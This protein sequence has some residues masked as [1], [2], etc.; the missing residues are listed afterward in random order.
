MTSV[1]VAAQ[2]RRINELALQDV[3]SLAE[4]QRQCAAELKALPDAIKEAAKAAEY[5]EAARLQERIDLLKTQAEELA[6]ARA[7]SVRAKRRRAPA[8]LLPADAVKSQAASVFG[9]RV[10][11][12]VEPLRPCVDAT[13]AVLAEGLRIAASEGVSEVRIRRAPDVDAAIR[14]KHV[15]DPAGANSR[16]EHEIRRAAS[17]GDV[18][19]REA[20]EAYVAKVTRVLLKVQY[21]VDVGFCWVPVGK[22][23]GVPADG[24]AAD[25]EWK[26]DFAILHAHHDAVAGFKAEIE[27]D[28]FCELCGAFDGDGTHAFEH[29]SRAV[30]ESEVARMLLR[31][32]LR[33]AGYFS[34]AHSGL[35]ELVKEWHRKNHAARATN[36]TADALSF[37]SE[38][39]RAF[40][41]PGA[42]PNFGGVCFHVAHGAAGAR[43]AKALGDGVEATAGFTRADKTAASFEEYVEACVAAASSDTYESGFYSRRNATGANAAAR[44]VPA[45]TEVIAAAGTAS[46]R[47]LCAREKFQ[48]AR[49][50]EGEAM[51][52]PASPV[53]TPA[54]FNK[55]YT[56][57]LS[58]MSSPA[59]TPASSSRGR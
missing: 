24:D 59:S 49:R 1:D 51:M 15:F 38:Q 34:R 14:S 44:T 43:L 16:A 5:K 23:L 6:A 52:S 4:R 12:V 50:D 46:L 36:P 37:R 21:F 58:S 40:Q 47:N 8:A 11:E 53:S 28:A 39:F 25:A 20:H 2:Q 22:G 31:W 29:V 18:A 48:Q 56:P 17:H 27:R 35:A 26:D 10:A 33:D 41:K 45:N 54:G 42:L 9:E 3:D 32:R 19:Y 57:S 7:M 55:T 30:T 13:L